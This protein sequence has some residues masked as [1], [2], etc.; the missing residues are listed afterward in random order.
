MKPESVY[1]WLWSVPEASVNVWTMV[2]NIALNLCHFFGKLV[3]CQ[4][5]IHIDSNVV[6]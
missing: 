1:T 3:A 5:D 4:S 6:I 2:L